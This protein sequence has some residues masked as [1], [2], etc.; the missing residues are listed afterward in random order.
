MSLKA[1]LLGSSMYA[2]E[3][4]FFFICSKHLP[5]DSKFQQKLAEMSKYSLPHFAYRD[6]EAAFIEENLFTL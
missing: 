3:I 2:L 1:D 6:E 5:A 4:Y